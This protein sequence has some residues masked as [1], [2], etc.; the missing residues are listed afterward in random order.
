[1]IRLTRAIPLAALASAV[2]V[3]AACR[4]QTPPE[5]TPTTVAT[6]PNADSAAREQARR[7]S[8]ER[9]R[10][11]EEERRLAE[12][13][14]ADS[15]AAAERAVADAAAALNNQLVMAIHFDF[16]RAEVL[17][18]DRANLD[19][20]A[21]ILSANPAV[22]IRIAGHADERG[23]DEYNMALG[24]RRAAA[25]K[26]YLESRGVASNRIEI[27]S[28]GEE[29]PVCQSHDEACWAQNRRGEFEIIAGGDARLRAP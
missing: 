14:R 18:Q 2:L 3:S 28:F 13:R 8:I 10:R 16:D 21:Q 25:T 15:I 23:S 6:T 7:D 22:R 11:R 12:R 20:K 17:E 4:R 24:Q 26:R 1:M 19:R 5:T 29:R 9:E 27:V